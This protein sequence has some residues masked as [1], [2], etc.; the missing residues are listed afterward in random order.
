MPDNSGPRSL[1][2]RFWKTCLL[3]FGGV[4][5]MTLTIELVKAIWWILAIAA[6]VTSVIWVAVWWWRRRNT[7]Q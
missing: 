3:I 1:A 4:I 2:E 6:V 5:L 7:W